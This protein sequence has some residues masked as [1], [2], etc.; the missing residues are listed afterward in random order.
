MPRKLPSRD[1]IGAYR[2]KVV[3][4]RRVG[5]DI[6]CSCGEKRP[7][8]LIPG[9]KPTTCA[10]CQ[11]T[12]SGRTA[13]DNHHFAGKANSPTTIPVPVNDHRAGLSVSQAD[14]P[15]STL[16][17]AQGSPLLA[18]AACLR[19]FV[20][21]VLYLIEQGLLWIAEMLEK[22]D[23]FLAK[24]LG[25]K[26]WHETEIEPFAPNKRPNGHRS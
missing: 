15:K 7:E 11:R 13:I 20:D 14:W 17:N 3:A 18:A 10:A 8:G 16:I 5:L 12:A 2:R 23:V 22:L 19:G 4:A 26:W 9:S 1:A 21:S 6:H 25:A 24:K